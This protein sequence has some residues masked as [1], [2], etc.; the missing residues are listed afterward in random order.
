[1]VETKLK[2][3]R[4][5]LI[6]EI[7]RRG[8]ISSIKLDPAQKEF[9]RLVKESD[10][11]IPVILSSR[12]LGKTW[13]ALVLSLETCLKTPNAVVKFVA[14][15]KEM[16]NDIVEKTMPQILEDCPALLQP[17]QYKSKY[18]YKFHNGSRLEM[19]GINSGHADKIRGGYA[20][21]IIVDE[22]GFCN[23]LLNTIRRVLTPLTTNTMGKIILLSTPPDDLEHD[24]LK[25][26][27]EAEMR[28]VLIKKT[29]YDNPRIK[30]E[31]IEHILAAYPGREKH[32]D[33]RREY[34]C[35]IQKNKELS[36]IPEFDDELVKSIVKP[37]KKP[38]MFDG[39]VGMD[40]GFKD[41][42]VVV[43]GYYD[44]RAAKLI[45]EDEI[46]MNFQIQANTL[47]KLVRQ[48]HEKEQDIFSDPMTHELKKPAMRVSDI[49]Y[50]V[51]KEIHHFSKGL[52]SFSS[53]KKDDKQ[54]A[55]NNLR[56]LL[57]TEKVII[58]PKCTTVISHLMN[59]KWSKTNKAIFDRSPDHGHYDAVDALLY[60]SRAVDFN[61]NPYPRGYD[62][63]QADLY[64]KPEVSNFSGSNSP[65]VQN[66]KTLFKV[67]RKYVR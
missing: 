44:F 31:E 48:M 13:W 18:V 6:E 62:Y 30:P 45:I 32:P 14:P 36:V 22:A 26:V 19:A 41:L 59:A 3:D 42:T 40:L 2:Y 58:N 28:G 17:N 63:E 46:V 53:A 33:F 35:Q 39:Y 24:F 8:S 9:D 43:F 50:I 27:E 66:M 56:I 37:W 65:I 60:L 29:I 55:I 11:T 47:Q 25:L 34:L 64:V 21:L 16:I 23:D 4:N 5:V 7:W 61:K 15:T 52:I 12:R 49:N 51:L 67:G 20:N 10:E 38:T 54:A 1:M 57:A